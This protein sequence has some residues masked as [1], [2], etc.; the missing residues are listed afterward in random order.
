MVAAGK[1]GVNRLRTPQEVG[2]GQ[3]A[4]D[5]ER[6]HDCEERPHLKAITGGLANPRPALFM[7][8][9]WITCQRSGKN[10]QSKAQ[11][12]TK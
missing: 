7:A 10:N 1:G 9:V 12:N 2:H 6:I 8:H 11:T 4:E 3:E 5:Q